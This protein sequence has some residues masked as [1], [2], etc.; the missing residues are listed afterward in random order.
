[1]TN[2]TLRRLTA[3]VDELNADSRRIAMEKLNLKTSIENYCKSIV[4]LA[5]SGEIAWTDALGLIGAMDRELLWFAPYIIRY[6]VR[7][8]PTEAPYEVIL[9]GDWG[10]EVSVVDKLAEIHERML[11]DL[12]DYGALRV[13]ED[14]ARQLV[15]RW[16]ETGYT[17]SFYVD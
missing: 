8:V 16:E 1:M 7:V 15:L 4:K 2:T 13:N 14:V 3:A 6:K 9:G 17:G 5:T 12:A 10:D 11:V